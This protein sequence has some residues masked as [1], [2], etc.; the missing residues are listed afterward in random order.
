MGAGSRAFSR[1][2]PPAPRNSRGGGAAAATSLPANFARNNPGGIARF[3][4][5]YL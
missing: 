5:F 4:Y 2:I 1:D 3:S